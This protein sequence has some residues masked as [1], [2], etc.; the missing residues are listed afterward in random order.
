MISEF[1]KMKGCSLFSEL[2]L[3]NHFFK[4]VSANVVY[5]ITQVMKSSFNSWDP[6]PE[7]LGDC[8]CF[9]LR[10]YSW[11]CL[12]FPTCP[13]S[14]TNLRNHSHDLG[15]SFMASKH[16]DLFHA[17]SGPEPGN[18][19]GKLQK[20]GTE[21]CFLFS[22]PKDCRGCAGHRIR[23]SRQEWQTLSP[24]GLCCWALPRSPAQGTDGMR[25]HP[26]CFSAVPVSPGALFSVATHI[27]RVTLTSNILSSN[28]HSTYQLCDLSRCSFL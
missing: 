23:V 7:V 9:S 22:K 21:F 5:N 26:S 6:E 19:R 8:L 16:P 27:L 3:N 12:A 25:P 4:K 1:F 2:Y 11:H 18:N 24:G 15:T 10:L 28:S 13:I 20:M 17:P 14:T